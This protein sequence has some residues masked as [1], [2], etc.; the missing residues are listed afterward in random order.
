MVYAVTQEFDI[1]Q[2]RPWTDEMHVS[3]KHAL[4]QNYENVAIASSRFN[5]RLV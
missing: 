4:N 3:R 5:T 2:C 1:M